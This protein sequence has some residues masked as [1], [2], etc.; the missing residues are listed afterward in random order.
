MSELNNA[1]ESAPF[2]VELHYKIEGELPCEFYG[3]IANEADTYTNDVLVDI[4]SKFLE[5]G[6]KEGTIDLQSLC[7]KVYKRLKDVP[8]GLSKDYRPYIISGLLKE[9]QSLSHEQLLEVARACLYPNY[10]RNNDTARLASLFV[11]VISQ[12]PDSTQQ[13]QNQ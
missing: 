7:N 12:V 10:I 5:A 11:P 3:V 6:Y 2:N 1:K 13:P 4:H 8:Q 9:L